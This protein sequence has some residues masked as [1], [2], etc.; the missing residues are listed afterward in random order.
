MRQEACHLLPEPLAGVCLAVGRWWE[1]RDPAREAEPQPEGRSLAA[2]VTRAP[3]TIITARLQ[4][5]T[6]VSN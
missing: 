2:R 3:A 6:L 1:D 4:V 5:T